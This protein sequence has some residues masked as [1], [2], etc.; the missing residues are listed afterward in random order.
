MI[1][2]RYKNDGRSIVP[3]RLRQRKARK[4]LLD[5]IKYKYK[6]V[7]RPC[8]CGVSAFEY[9]SEKDAF[10]IPLHVVICEMCGLIQVSPCCDQDSYADFYRNIYP[11][12]YGDNQDLGNLFLDLIERGEWIFKFIEANVNFGADYFGVQKSVLEIGCSAGGILAAF[13]NRG[14]QI[15]GTDYDSEVVEYGNGCGLNLFC[16]HSDQLDIT[17]EKKYD[18]I[19]LSHV[20]E[21]FVNLDYELKQIRRLLKV[22][23]L[24]Y[25]EVPSI[26]SSL[27]KVQSDFLDYLEFDHVYY[28]GLNTLEQTL[29]FFGFRMV[30]GVEKSGYAACALF[31]MKEALGGS[32]VD[33]DNTK[34]INYY[35]HVMERLAELENKYAE[36]K[37]KHFFIRQMK[38][39]PLRYKVKIKSIIG[40]AGIPTR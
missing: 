2:E 27:G 39:L 23:G 25:V 15:L 13:K 1:A 10:G 32:Y 34:N 38:L 17:H 16:G 21:H 7:A 11:Q 12:L 40:K 19:I 26:Y 9:L 3:L 8:V 22:G 14:H 30:A 18:L 6:F 36:S 20:F 29:R 28:F 31:E 33:S 24:V 5:N 35:H 4:L 37:L